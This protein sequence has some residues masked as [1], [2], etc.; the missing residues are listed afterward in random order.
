M[1]SLLASLILCAAA[2]TL[3]GQEPVADSLQNTTGGGLEAPAPQ[4]A[5]ADSRALWDEANTA[6]LRSDFH[7]ASRIY[8]QILERGEHSSKLYYNLGNASFKEEKLGEAILYYHRALRLNPADEDARYNLSVAENRT[9]DRIETI[10]EFFL[11]TWMRSVRSLLSG[12]AWT[13][14]S[15]I[16]LT[17]TLGAVLFYL[18]SQRLNLR[19]AGF[20]TTLCA[21]LLFLVCT[22]FAAADRSEQIS[23]NKAVVLST[24]VPV[25]SSPD[26]AAT[27]LFV[28]HEG[29]TLDVGEQMGDWSEITLADGK[30]GWL[31]SRHIEVI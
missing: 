18:L 23:R 7:T 9:I 16:L 5:E 28:L 17:L 26:K 4:A 12:T 20:Y 19:K 27:D 11:K 31:E 22:A 2:L 14:L 6:Y 21:L 25:K 30:K 24:S 3:Y 8:R 13:I 15:L 10:P 29:T 1:K